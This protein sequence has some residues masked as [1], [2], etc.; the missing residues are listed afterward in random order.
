[1]TVFATT[2]ELGLIAALTLGPLGKPFIKGRDGVLLLGGTV[3]AGLITPL[4]VLLGGLILRYVCIDAGR[5]SA[6]DPQATHIY[7][8]IEW[9]E[10][11]DSQ[12]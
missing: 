6:D 12:R 5:K 7:N 11:A 4:L 10:R 9:Q 2:T 8:R 3:D 1:M